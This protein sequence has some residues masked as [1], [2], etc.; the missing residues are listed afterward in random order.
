MADLE[1]ASVHSDVNEINSVT[2]AEK[3]LDRV[4]TFL[5]F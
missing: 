4:G 3:V 2:H 5:I 1:R